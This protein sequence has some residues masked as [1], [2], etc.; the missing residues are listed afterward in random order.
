MSA[1]N[2]LESAIANYLF[3]SVS[4][5]SPTQIKIGLFTT[6]PNE[7]GTGGVEP[8]AAE[9]ARV[10]YGP[11]SAYWTEPQS[12]DGVVSNITTIIFPAP[13]GA[14][15]GTIVGFGIWD[16]SANLLFDHVFATSVVVGSGSDAPKFDPGTLRVIFS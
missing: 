14:A 6:M 10:L 13:T 15:W 1:S 5:T 8:S 12:G 4:L 7:Y 11:G 2:Y 16:Q 3:R 9:Y